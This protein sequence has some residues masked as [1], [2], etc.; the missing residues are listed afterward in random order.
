MAA[1]RRVFAFALTTQSLL[2]LL[3]WGL[4][5]VL[6]VAPRW[7]SVRRD[8][9]IGLAGAAVLAVANYLLLVYGP[10]NW[11][12]GGVR[13]VYHEVLVPLF[14]KFGPVSIF[15]IGA[16]AG[17][18]EEWLF[19]GV[20]QPIVGLVAASVLFGVAHVGNRTMMAFGMWA[21]GMGLLLGALAQATGGLLAPIVA[22]GVYDMLA[23]AY[24]RRGAL[25]T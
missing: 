2:I 15:V 5:R 3:A 4:S 6:D 19:R 20:L 12:V 11:V 23:L 13:A 18:G 8:L 7:G 10:R 25:K 21:T 22:H 16:F 24:I 17:I 14:S 9:W 1:A